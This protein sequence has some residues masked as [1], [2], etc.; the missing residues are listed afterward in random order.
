VINVPA[1]KLA[2][3][4]VKVGNS[5]GRDMPAERVSAPLVAEYFA[6]LECKFTDTRLNKYNLF[7]LEVLKARRDPTASCGSSTRT[8]GLAKTSCPLA[9][10]APVYEQAG[11]GGGDHPSR[12]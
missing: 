9:R 5:S 3:T 7:I 12:G 4:V 1:R 10:K 11:P 8:S 2:T 6:N